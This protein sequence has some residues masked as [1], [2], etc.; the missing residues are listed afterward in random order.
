MSKKMLCVI[1]LSVL[2]APCAFAGSL[3][4]VYAKD[5]DGSAEGSVHYARWDD[6]SQK[7]EK[8]H[9]RALKHG[10]DRI[11]LSPGKYRIEVVYT[12]TMPQQQSVKEDLVI[13]DGEIH[14]T[15]FYFEKGAARI[16]TRDND[17]LWDAHT[18]LF[19]SKRDECGSVY[20]QI[21]ACELTDNVTS[22]YFTLAPGAYK[23]RIQYT[24]TMPEDEY[25][26]VEFEVANNDVVP[27][28][29]IFKH[30]PLPTRRKHNP[31]ARKGSGLVIEPNEALTERTDNTG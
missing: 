28:V 15:E 26:E 4:K 27:I 9:S 14:S 8:L 13:G 2:I 18:R 25:A 7:Y 3:M 17:W 24:E 16:K 23:L 1:M 10:K 29:A 5:L 30:G 21:Q 22:R 19:L 11:G 20:Q 31:D 12:E 6:T